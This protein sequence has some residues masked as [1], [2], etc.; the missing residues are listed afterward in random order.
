MYELPSFEEL[1]SLIYSE[2]EEKEEE[3]P[4]SDEYMKL[5]KR[6]EVGLFLAKLTSYVAEALNVG[7][8][9][10]IDVEPVQYE[11]VLSLLSTVLP[12]TPVWEE[13][14][15]FRDRS[16]GT[17]LRVRYN[18]YNLAQPGRREVLVTIAREETRRE[19]LYDILE[20]VLSTP[21]LIYFMVTPVRP[22]ETI[23]TA[24]Y[25]SNMILNAIATT[26][27]LLD[28]KYGSITDEYREKLRYLGRVPHEML[29]FMPLNVVRG[30]AQRWAP[31]PPSPSDYLRKPVRSYD[32]LQ[33]PAYLKELLMR[34]VDAVKLYGSGTLMLVGLHGSGKKTIARFLAHELELPAY[35]LSVV[36]LL[37]KYVGESEAKLR[38][39]FEAL[40]ARGGL[41]VFENVDMLF[42][43]TK[44]ENVTPNL[45]NVLFQ[46]LS[47]DDNNFVVVFT[48]VEDSPSAMFDSP[49]LG[50]VKFVIPPPNK[51][52]R[53]ELAKMFL[54]EISGERWN[55][56]LRIAARVVGGEDKAESYLYSIYAKPFADGAVGFT[57]REI[58]QV[59][60]FVLLP[61]IK[62]TVEHERFAPIAGTLEKILLQ[63]YSAR[64]AKLRKLKERAISFGMEP[65]ADFILKLEE[66]V[67][68][69][70]RET[71]RKM[72][73]YR[74]L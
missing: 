56:L 54:R 39:F 34:Y 11:S 48:A 13:K 66:E 29:L 7:V 71:V 28:M 46:E 72:E 19:K 41:A 49:L 8:K 74:K 55:T 63:D 73:K 21:R 65:I 62:Y 61:A 16:T 23:T 15:R 59:M 22:E 42:R 35:H 43:E 53:Y 3:I 31:P 64:L 12:C 32:E 5:C 69:K 52:M 57:P 37:S 9:I 26:L 70:A 67:G 17:H 47:R 45:R 33:L 30:V 2:E 4:I 50:E 14:I 27:K 1:D 24:L 18:M 36:N 60:R 51:E 6:T 58:Y 20:S 38:K 10:I 44:Q 68:A 25:S 40:R